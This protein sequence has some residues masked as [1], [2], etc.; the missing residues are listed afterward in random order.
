MFLLNIFFISSLYAHGIVLNPPSRSYLCAQ[1][2][3]IQCGNIDNY[4]YLID[5]CG[6]PLDNIEQVPDGQ[7]AGTTLPQNYR[8]NDQHD[9]R[10]SF[11]QFNI[12]RQQ[13]A[14]YNFTYVWKITSLPTIDQNI[15]QIFLSNPQYFSQ[16]TVMNR[17]MFYTSPLCVHTLEPFHTII[18]DMLYN[19]TCNFTIEHNTLPDTTPT[20]AYLLFLWN[21]DHCTTYYQIADV[22]LFVWNQE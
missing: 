7:F 18:V 21:T 1:G 20:L 14:Y 4:D 19:F 6:F 2:I 12:T 11:L 3:N 9:N 17:E 5:S 13:N 22:A 10:W 8:L 15:F 16:T